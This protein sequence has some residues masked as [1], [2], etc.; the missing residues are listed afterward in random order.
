MPSRV[1]SYDEKGDPDNY[2]H[3]FERA[4]H[5]K[6]WAMPVACHMFT[7]T[8]KYSAI[9]WWNSQKASSILN[10][11]D[12]KAKFWSDG[13]TLGLKQEKWQSTELRATEGRV[14]TCLRKI[15]PGTTTKDRKTKTERKSVEESIDEVA[16]ITFPP[17]LS[18]NSSYPVIIKARIS[19]RQVNRV[20]L[21]RLK[22]SAR[23]LLRGTLLA[24]RRSTFGNYNRTSMQRMGI[25]VS[26][27]HG[28]IKF[29]TPRGIGTVFSTH[30]IDKAREE[31]KKLKGNSQK[32]PKGILSCMEAKET[33]DVDKKYPEQ[34]IIIGK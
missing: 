16:E 26:T 5:M 7:Y 17:V 9:I 13:E 25:V 30:E 27:I 33:I 21:N 8:L 24:S 29:H 31:Q 12:L 11:K 18:I 14:S 20:P 22:D 3:L 15:L 19:E 1:G 28:A 23:W 32:T 10:Y 2:L 4:I 6:K 34:T